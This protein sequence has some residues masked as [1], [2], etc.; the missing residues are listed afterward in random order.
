[1]NVF[2]RAVFAVCLSNC[3]YGVLLFVQTRTS[4]FHFTFMLY[5][6]QLGCIHFFWLQFVFNDKMFSLATSCRY[7]YRN[8]CRCSCCCLYLGCFTVAMFL[9]NDNFFY[10]SPQ[11]QLIRSV[12]SLSQTLPSSSSTSLHIHSCRFFL[13]F[14]SVSHFTLLQFL[15]NV[16]HAGKAFILLAHIE[17]SASGCA[18]VHTLRTNTMQR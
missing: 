11:I 9:S 2:A 18:F 7:H 5:V 17:R 15:L 12:Q 1:M 13:F 14:L 10:K 16:E 4:I 6:C 8:R 3:W